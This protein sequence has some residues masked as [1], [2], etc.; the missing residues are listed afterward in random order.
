M[1]APNGSIANLSVTRKSLRSHNDKNSNLGVW[2]NFTPRSFA[3]A[4]PLRQSQR[5]GA[6][7]KDKI[8]SRRFNG[9]G[10]GSNDF[11]LR[12]RSGAAGYRPI[13]FAGWRRPW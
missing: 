7:Q 8:K 5:I 12:R 2:F 9:A 10:L 3:G 1:P 13:T 4:V 6:R 11:F